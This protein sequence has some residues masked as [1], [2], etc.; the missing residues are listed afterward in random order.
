MGFNIPTI[1][2]TLVYVL[3]VWIGVIALGIKL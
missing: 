3:L 1:L 2:A